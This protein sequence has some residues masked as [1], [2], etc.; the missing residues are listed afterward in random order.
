MIG[1]PY[2]ERAPVAVNLVFFHERIRYL[3][4][5]EMSYLSSRCVVEAHT[6]TVDFR[7]Y[8]YEVP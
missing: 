2:A 1:E 5:S 4:T 8:Q 3:L 7:G 6:H